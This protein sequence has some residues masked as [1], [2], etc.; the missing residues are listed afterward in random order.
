MGRDSYLFTF[1][2]KGPLYALGFVLTPKSQQGNAWREA[3]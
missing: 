3:L 2:H 1:V